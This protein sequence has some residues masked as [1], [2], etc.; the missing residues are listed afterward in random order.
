MRII[1]ENN[2]TYLSLLYGMVKK[3]SNELRRQYLKKGA[4]A[5]FGSGLSMGTASATDRGWSVLADGKTEPRPDTIERLSA[6]GNIEDIINNY[7]YDPTL[8]AGLG[9]SITVE[10]WSKECSQT[11]TYW[12]ASINTCVSSATNGPSSIF[13]SQHTTNWTGSDDAVLADSTPRFIGGYDGGN[14]NDGNSDI[15]ES[16]A[17]SAVV[18]LVGTGLSLAT[19][20]T[21]SGIATSMT[22]ALLDV[23]NESSNQYKRVW[24]WSPM[25]EQT[26]VWTK[27]DLRVFD[28][29]S[30]TFDQAHLTRLDENG[31]PEL[32]GGFAFD[33]NPPSTP[34]LPST[35][36]FLNLARGNYS[37]SAVLK[38]SRSGKRDLY[39]S[40][41][42]YVREHPD[43]FSLSDSR[44][45]ELPDDGVVLSAPADPTFRPTAQSPEEF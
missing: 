13:E 8:A 5:I 11:G 34:D 43:E 45:R 19:G 14:Y 36:S 27:Y 1:I 32:F 28:G 30:E 12:D 10:E 42:E 37:M 6:T 44:I 31:Y 18:A 23:A 2:I 39:A 7:P 16:L 40:S 3:P 15:A 41:G 21:G 25:Q 29:E 35:D 26:S 24:D 38:K 4:A 20:F 33:M 22:A 17:Q 9:G